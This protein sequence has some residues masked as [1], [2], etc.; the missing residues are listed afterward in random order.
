MLL[1]DSDPPNEHF[2]LQYLSHHPT[3]DPVR[4]PLLP[5]LAEWRR[6]PDCPVVVNPAASDE[7]NLAQ[8]VEILRERNIIGVVNGSREL[9]AQWH[10][11]A[12]D[13]IIPSRQFFLGRDEA[14]PEQLAADFQAGEFQVFGEIGNQYFGY[15]PNAP[16]FEPYWTMAEENDIPVGIHIGYMP[17]GAGY[18]GIGARISIA[19]PLLL[20]EVLIHHPRLRVYV[21]HSGYPQIERTI[22]LMQTYPQVYADTGMLQAILTRD[23]YDTFLERMFNAGLGKRLMYGTDQIIWPE[24]ILY[25]L[26]VVESSTVL[27]HAQKRDLLYNNAARFFRLDGASLAEQ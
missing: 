16:E 5:T 2:C 6:N 10:A 19:D 25:S 4:Q 1:E 14:S 18:W 27:T 11:A 8:T 20:E 26:E 7:A 15:A 22:A 13:R 9:V 21:M 23:G 17:P 12:P 24:M 3:I